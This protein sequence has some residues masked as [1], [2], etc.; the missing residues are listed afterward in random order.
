[1]K[2]GILLIAVFISLGL[3]SCAQD[4]N[5]STA[6]E[7]TEQPKAAKTVDL[8]SFRMTGLDGKE[9]QL[10]DLKGKK[11]FVNI[12]ATWCPPCRREMP[13]IAALYNSVDKNKVAFIMLDVDD[14]FEKARQYLAKN[15]L[16]LPAFYPAENLPPLFNVQGIP[17]T[18]IFDE[19]GALIETINGSTDYDTDAFRQMLK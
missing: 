14:N 11:V 13:S 10:A 7:V 4:N 19:D 8:P 16:G 17:A 6:T 9:V 2:N 12:W 18:F 3:I 5:E 1:M 15:Q